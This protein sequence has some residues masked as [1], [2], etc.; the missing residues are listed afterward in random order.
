[1]SSTKASLKNAQK[2]RHRKGKLLKLLCGPNTASS[3]GVPLCDAYSLMTRKKER[4][5]DHVIGTL[6]G[7]I[8][9]WTATGG[10]AFLHV[11]YRRY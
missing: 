7:T 5:L 6:K 11:H 9:E 1:M 10:H 8:R 4:F 2:K 3:E